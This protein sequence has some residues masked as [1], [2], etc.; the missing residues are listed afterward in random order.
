MASYVTTQDL[1]DEVDTDMQDCIASAIEKLE[2]L[3]N[4]DDDA[5][6]LAMIDRVQARLAWLDQEIQA[7]KAELTSWLSVDTSCD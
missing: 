3:L 2:A 4:T 1:R 7:E 6:L 5:K